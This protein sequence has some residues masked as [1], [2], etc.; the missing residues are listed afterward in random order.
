[1][2][3]LIVFV[4]E[5]GHFTV[6]KLCGMRVREFMIGLPG[7]NLGFS[8]GDTRF[9]IT[10]FLLG[11]YALIAGM[12]YESES[13][14]LADTLAE[15]AA[16]GQMDT[17]AVQDRERELGFDL[18]GDLDQL[19]D[20]G[21]IQRSRTKNG[22]YLYAMN[23]TAD[24]K[25][26]AARTLD[27]PQATITAERKLTYLGAPYYQRVLMLLAGALFNLVFAIIVFTAAMMYIGDSQTT[28]TLESITIDS[29]AE[30]AGI[31]PG[32]QLLALDG[33][34]VSSW[35]EFYDKVGE[36]T[37]GDKITVTVLRAGEN[38]DFSLTLAD[39]SGRAF[40]GVSPTVVR[41]PVGLTEALARSFGFIGIV[42]VTI[43]SL[44][45][46]ATF[47]QVISQSSS[48]VGISVEAANAAE[49][50]FLP[51]IALA[52]AL[53]ISIGLMNVLPIPPLDGGKIVL[54]TIQRIIGRPIPSKIINNISVAALVLLGLLFV[55]VTWQD[56]QR[57]FI[58]G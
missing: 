23:A 12:Q 20:W 44:L 34:E 16:V 50:G 5:A 2:F 41:T 19:A 29:P 46:P 6:A 26:G 31:M 47:G 43:I 30:L 48:V 38:L 53:S 28:T 25:R 35:Q 56:I 22:L 17:A 55:V 39:N 15:L 14:T 42:A 51:F 54:E 52:A 1:M 58:A 27:D 24:S 33:Q 18:E 36:Y 9:G 45:N 37:P 7:P 49:A 32:D 4:H 11:G 21:T 8:I 57:Y 40:L 3:S 13:P 10:P